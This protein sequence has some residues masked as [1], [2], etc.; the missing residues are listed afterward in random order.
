MHKLDLLILG[1]A[2]AGKTSMIRAFETGE[3]IKQEGD[4]NSLH[5]QIGMSVTSQYYHL[6]M[7]QLEQMVKLYVW[8]PTV[9]ELTKEES[10]E[11]QL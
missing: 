5:R 9:R 10:E 7:G 8:D 6:G 3:E 2:K 11:P 4:G 1:P